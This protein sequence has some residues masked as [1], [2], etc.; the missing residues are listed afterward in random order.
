MNRLLILPVLILT[1]LL[2]NPAFS[3]DFQK[4]WDAAQS[5]D[6]ATALREWTPLAEQG[7]AFAQT[8]LGMMYDNGDGVP[9]DKKSAV[10]WYRLAAEQRYALA[11]Y[12]LG[13]MYATGNGV[14]Q[15]YIH[16]DMWWNFA[17]SQGFKK[18]KKNRKIIAK[19]MNPSQLEKA[20]KLA[21]ECVRK[22]YKG[23]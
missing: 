5:G 1:L 17:A 15:N 18:A 16:A 23:C 9:Q 4:G 3:A 6:F 7:D 14:L 19:K 20:Q 22:K 11:Q 13:Y 10:K 12:S 2:G 21:R 8:L